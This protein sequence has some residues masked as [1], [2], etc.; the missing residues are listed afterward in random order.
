MSNRTQ[1]YLKQPTQ[2]KPIT[3]A[4]AY[5]DYVNENLERIERDGWVPVSYE[6]FIDSEECVE[7]IDDSKS[8]YGQLLRKYKT[9]HIS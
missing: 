1:Y 6:E 2:M 3:K 4:E 9:F 8:L 7:R 5:V